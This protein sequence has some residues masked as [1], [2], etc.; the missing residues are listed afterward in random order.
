MKT[1][2]ALLNV[3]ALLVLSAC[4]PNGSVSL[5]G[6]DLSTS[7]VGSDTYVNMEAIIAMGSLKFPSMEVPVVNP[8]N[9]QVLGSMSLSSLADGTNRMYVSIDYEAATKL[10]PTSGS[11][12]PNQREL[13]LLMGMTSDTTMIGIPILEKSRIYIGGDLKKDLYVGAAITIP[14]FD[15]ALNQVPFPL[16]VFFGFPFS[17]QVSGYAGLFTGPQKGEN[18]IAVFVKKTAP[19]PSI[20]TPSLMGRTLASVKTNSTPDAPP[21]GVVSPTGGEEMSKMSNTNMFRLARLLKRNATIKV[22]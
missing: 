5:K 9:M 13:P 17:N 16:N 3:A 2:I 12:L 14:A 4:S 6:V 8:K 19:T 18:G 20:P 7:Q 22:R 1:K 21:A 10:D 11:T 15:T